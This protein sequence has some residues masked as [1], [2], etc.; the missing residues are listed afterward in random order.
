MAPRQRRAI[1]LLFLVVVASD[2][3]QYFLF[4]TLSIADSHRPLDRPFPL[5]LPAA[6][7][8]LVSSSYKW[9]IKT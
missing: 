9:I 2:L 6:A 1:G 3:P 7:V 4:G 8:I 5:Q